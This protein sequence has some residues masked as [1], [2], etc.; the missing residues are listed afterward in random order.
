MIIGSGQEP[1]ELHIT[2]ETNSETG[3]S[4]GVGQ[5]VCP[6]YILLVSILFVVGKVA[7]AC[8]VIT[9]IFYPIGICFLPACYFTTFRIINNICIFTSPA[10]CFPLT[11]KV[12]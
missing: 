8:C 7:N 3:D 6:E 2:M 4:D 9:P 1:G 11:L 10:V 12:L 5:A